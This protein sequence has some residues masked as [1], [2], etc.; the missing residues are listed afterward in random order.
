MYT[1]MYLMKR[2]IK[3]LI[4]GILVRNLISLDI[5][6]PV[7]MP[8]TS[9]NISVN[10]NDVRKKMLHGELN[11]WQVNMFIIFFF[12]NNDKITP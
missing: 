11:N 5:A 9:K 6:K 7:K 10:K 12:L 8:L 1:Y 4:H 2:P 3:L